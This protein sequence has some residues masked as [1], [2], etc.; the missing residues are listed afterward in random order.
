MTQAEALTRVNKH[1]A[2]LAKAIDERMRDEQARQQQS[3]H[4]LGDRVDTRH[5]QTTLRMNKIEEASAD[6]IRKLG[7]QIVTLTTDMQGRVD[8]GTQ[9][10]RDKVA[11]IGQSTEQSVENLRRKLERRLEGVEEAQKNLD[12]YSGPDDLPRSTPASTAWNTVLSPHHRPRP[13]RT[14]Q[15]LIPPRSPKQQT[16]LTR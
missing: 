11:D 8:Q 13:W 14:H 2:G 7:D 10:I 5:A 16:P 12:S 15:R 1:I 3:L 4:M 6:A 9:S